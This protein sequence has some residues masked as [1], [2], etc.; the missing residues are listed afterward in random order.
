M[1]GLHVNLHLLKPTPDSDF[2][3]CRGRIKDWHWGKW[4]FSKLKAENHCP[5]EMFQVCRVLVHDL[6]LH[7]REYVLKQR[8]AEGLGYS[9]SRVI[10]NLLEC[11]LIFSM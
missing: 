10:M 7:T 3:K 8:M 9:G 11:L 4:P 5:L 6:F 1:H 2:L